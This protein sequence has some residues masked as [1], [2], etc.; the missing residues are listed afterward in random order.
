MSELEGYLFP[1][2]V[3]ACGI[4]ITRSNEPPIDQKQTRLGHQNDRAN[5]D[6]SESSQTRIE[7]LGRQRP[8][9]FRCVLEEVGF[10]YSVVMSQ[11]LTASRVSP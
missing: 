7:E 10:C 2:D 5:L 11:L 9:R 3:M 8:E 6:N 4:E 1:G